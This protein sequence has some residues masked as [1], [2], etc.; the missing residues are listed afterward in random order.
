[1]IFGFTSHCYYY[2]PGHF[3]SYTHI[4][5][6]NPPQFIHTVGENILHFVR[7]YFANTE[8][9]FLRAMEKIPCCIFI[10]I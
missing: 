5:L 10:L 8:L 3:N 9:S 7:T 1:M 4:K 2:Q 6:W